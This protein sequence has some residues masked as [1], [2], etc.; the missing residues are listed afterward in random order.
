MHGETKIFH[1]NT[2]FNQYLST[3]QHLPRIIDGEL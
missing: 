3:N 2:K 1:D